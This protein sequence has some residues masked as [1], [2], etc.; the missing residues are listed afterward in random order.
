MNSVNKPVVCS[1]PQLNINKRI[2]DEGKEE[3]QEF[4]RE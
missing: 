4:R 1:L 3:K 2:A